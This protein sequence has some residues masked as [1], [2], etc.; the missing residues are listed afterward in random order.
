MTLRTTTWPALLAAAAGCFALAP[1]QAGERHAR[2]TPLLPAYRTECGSCHTPYPPGLLPAA[3]W[4]R[5]MGDLARHYGADASLDAPA[6]G[7]LSAWLAAN[8]AD[9]RR[10]GE[11]PPDDRITRSRWFAREHDEVRAAAWTSAAVKSRANCG[12]CHPQANQGDFDED[13]VRIPR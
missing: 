10:A 2:A 9:P 1:L 11:A 12:A 3:S 6:A 4:Q 7:Q 5:V 13:R 8:A